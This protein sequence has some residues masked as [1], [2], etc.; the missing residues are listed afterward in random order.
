MQKDMTKIIFFDIDGTL[1]SLKT[2]RTAPM[3]KEAIKRLQDKGILCFVASGRSMK[4]INDMPISDIDFDG[5]ITLNGQLGYMKDRQTTIYE[6]PF[7]QKT[8]SSLVKVFDEKKIS[9]MLVEKERSYHNIISEKTIT[10]YRM[11]G[12][13]SDLDIPGCDTYQGAAIF[14]AYTYVDPKSDDQSY[15]EYLP[16][17]G[18]TYKSWATGC[19]DIVRSDIS[20]V[21]GIK[22]ILEYYDISK[23]ATMA[24]GDAGND[25]EMLGFCAISV[26]MGN[27]DT[28]I[29]KIADYVT[30]DVDDKGVYKALAHFGLI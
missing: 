24:F 2:H 6:F 30:T 13:K 9:L 4:A 10:T 3:V 14:Q 17:D 21:E 23:D 7:D 27:A 16:K 20:K 8:T 1:V 5:Y 11:L 29:K 12:S 15:K 19:I 18:I 22:K 25:I 26:A 28:S